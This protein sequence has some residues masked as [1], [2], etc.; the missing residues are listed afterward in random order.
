[1]RQE[2][3]ATDLNGYA[4]F[5]QFVLFACLDI[6]LVDSLLFNVANRE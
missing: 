2:N 4:L 3:T 5:S 6:V 1:M